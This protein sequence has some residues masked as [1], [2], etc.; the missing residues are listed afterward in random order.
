ML[1][2]TLPPAFCPFLVREKGRVLV[3]VFSG[4]GFFFSL[5]FPLVV[6]EYWNGGKVGCE[7]KEIEKRSREMKAQG[8]AW[9]RERERVSGNASMR[10]QKGR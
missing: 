1:F 8:G 6:V 4:Y 5:S 9:R 3:L 10:K 7:E 2:Y